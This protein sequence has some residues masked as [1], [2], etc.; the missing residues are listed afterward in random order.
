MYAGLWRGRLTFELQE[1][2]IKYVFRATMPFRQKTASLRLRA[3]LKCGIGFDA[4]CEESR[5]VSVCVGSG[6]SCVAV[7]SLSCGAV[8]GVEASR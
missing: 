4:G 6:L 5:V 7:V 2:V 8:S 1:F 3:V